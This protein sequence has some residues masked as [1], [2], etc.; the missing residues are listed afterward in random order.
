MHLFLPR[1]QGGAE[2]PRGAWVCLGL[3]EESLD[4]LLERLVKRNHSVLGG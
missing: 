3:P 4:A 2:E 1:C